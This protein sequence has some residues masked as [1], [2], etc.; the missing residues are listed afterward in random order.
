MLISFRYLKQTLNDLDWDVERSDRPGG[1]SQEL[2]KPVSRDE[3]KVVSGW[4]V[5]I[6]QESMFSEPQNPGHHIQVGYFSFKK[7]ASFQFDLVFL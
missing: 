5:Y 2:Y 6:S 1:G 4:R 3:N 7:R